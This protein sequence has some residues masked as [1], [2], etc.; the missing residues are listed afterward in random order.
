ME[1]LGHRAEDRDRPVQFAQRAGDHPVAVVVVGHL[2]PDDLGHLLAHAANRG[3]GQAH[4]VRRGC[5]ADRMDDDGKVN[6]GGDGVQ[7]VDQHLGIGFGVPGLSDVTRSDRREH[8]QAVHPEICGVLRGPHR[9]RGGD[10]DHAGQ[11]RARPPASSSTI[12]TTRRRSSRSS[13]NSSPA[14]GL[15]ITAMPASPASGERKRRRK[16]RYAGSSISP[17]SS[18]GSTGVTNRLRNGSCRIVALWPGEGIPGR[19]KMS[20]RRIDGVNKADGR[21]RRSGVWGGHA[22]AGHRGNMEHLTAPPDVI[23]TATNLVPFE[24]KDVRIVDI[25]GS[26]RRPMEARA[27]LRPARSPHPGGQGREQGEG[28]RRLRIRAAD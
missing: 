14:S 3:G 9:S 28:F 8:E 12:R 22:R 18:N 5:L 26:T 7:Q 2:P 21:P 24:I 27:W 11:H 23:R 4:A 25:V 17:S 10:V 1:V 13:V 20:M 19:E 6:L 16:A 15:A